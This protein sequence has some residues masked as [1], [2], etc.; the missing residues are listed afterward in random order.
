MRSLYAGG[1]GGYALFLEV[2]EVSEVVEVIRCVL[3]CMLEVPEVIR[4][5]V[6]EVLEAFRCVLLCILE[7][8]ED[9]LCLPEVM[10]RVLSL[11]AGGDGGWAQKVSGFGNFRCGSLLTAPPP[12][13]LTEYSHI[14]AQQ[15]R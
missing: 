4:R 11:Y 10:H 2:L 15:Q 5:V 3:L 9:G 12:P 1:C 14:V 8:V 7:A 6:P 13:L